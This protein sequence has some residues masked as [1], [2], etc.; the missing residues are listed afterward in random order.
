[1]RNKERIASTN[2]LCQINDPS[3][4]RN[5]L[6]GNYCHF[7][8]WVRNGNSNSSL[9]KVSWIASP[10]KNSIRPF[11]QSQPDF[12]A[13][14]SSFP[15]DSRIRG[16]QIIREILLQVLPQTLRRPGL[17]LD[18]LSGPPIWG[19]NTLLVKFSN[20]ACPLSTKRRLKLRAAGAGRRLL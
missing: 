10:K 1:M 5:T 20:Q 3:S 17:C 7:L 2:H 19:S 9:Q 14:S 8:G 6:V 15:A 12:A 4:P 18:A 11:R 13:L 16:E